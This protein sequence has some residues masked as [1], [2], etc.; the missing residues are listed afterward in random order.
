MLMNCFGI[1]GY[2]LDLV[3]LKTRAVERVYDPCFS[4]ALWP[5]QSGSWAT[6]GRYRKVL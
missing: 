3:D 4:Q 2:L 5:A 1:L 6:L